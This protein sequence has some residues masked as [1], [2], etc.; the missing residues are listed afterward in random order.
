[1]TPA[2]L[3]VGLPHKQTPVVTNYHQQG[4]CLIAKQGG[5]GRKGTSLIETAKLNDVNPQAWLADTLTKLVN[6]WPK[7]QIDELMPWAYAKITRPAADV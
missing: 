2:A 5:L 6:H 7:A 3:T 4:S 1:M